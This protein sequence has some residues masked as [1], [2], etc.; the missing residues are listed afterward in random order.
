VGARTELGATCTHSHTHT[1]SHPLSPMS[2]SPPL[3]R[4]NVSSPRGRQSHNSTTFL[5][6]PPLS[7]P[8]LLSFLV[9]PSF[10]LIVSSALKLVKLVSCSGRLCLTLLVSLGD[11]RGTWPFTTAVLPDVR[12]LSPTAV[13]CSGVWVRTLFGLCCGGTPQV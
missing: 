2:R 4:N 12:P 9:S 11:W 7:F 5:H 6:L 1:H 10:L 13:S 3:Q 8:F